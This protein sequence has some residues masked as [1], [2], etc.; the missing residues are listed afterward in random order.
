MSSYIQATPRE[1]ALNHGPLFVM[2]SP[3]KEG[4]GYRYA[5][6]GLLVPKSLCPSNA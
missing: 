5:F 3:L 1:G 6:V 2:P 4:V